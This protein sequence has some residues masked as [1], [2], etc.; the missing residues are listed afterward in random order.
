MRKPA[1]VVHPSPGTKPST[2]KIT[3]PTMAMVVYWRLR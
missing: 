2:R 1:A 3:A